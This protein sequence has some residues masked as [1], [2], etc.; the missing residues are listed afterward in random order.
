MEG[1]EPPGETGSR[2][3]YRADQLHRAQKQQDSAGDEMEADRD[4]RRG[5]GRIMEALERVV[6]PR[7]QNT[8]SGSAE[9]EEDVGAKQDD[10]RPDGRDGCEGERKSTRLNSSK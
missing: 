7:G 5:H 2:A 8:E 9:E 6:P 4:H 10:H 1:P 3:A